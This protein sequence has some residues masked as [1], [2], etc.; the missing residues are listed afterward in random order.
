MVWDI[1]ITSKSISKFLQ[2]R[3]RNVFFQISHLY[4]LL[5]EVNSGLFF[6][7][8]WRNYLISHSE[9]EVVDTWLYGTDPQA[10]K[11]R[12]S[13][14]RIAVIIS[15]TPVLFAFVNVWALSGKNLNCSLFWFLMGLP[16][17]SENKAST[18]NVGYPGSIPG[19]GRTLG[20]GNDNPL[21]CSFLENS[22]DRGTWWASVHGVAKSQTRLR[23]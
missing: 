2:F 13:S 10:K 22:M 21:Q 3:T 14:Q 9:Y 6:E 17:G 11:G 19:W 7:V 23:D 16:G 4:S 12:L 15:L 1:S 18:G 8:C 5:G 20:E